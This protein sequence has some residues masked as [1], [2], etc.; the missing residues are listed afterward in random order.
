MKRVVQYGMLQDIPYKF[1]VYAADWILCGVK[2]AVFPF[3][4]RISLAVVRRS[5]NG[6]VSYCH[7]RPLAC[8]GTTSCSVRELSAVMFSHYQLQCSGTSSCSVQAP[9]AVIFRQH[10]LQIYKM[11]HLEGSVTPVLYI[12]RTVFKD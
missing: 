8:T 7:Q 12:G 10:Q 11:Q 5:N 2:P 1:A 9:P 4:T 3:D 6:T